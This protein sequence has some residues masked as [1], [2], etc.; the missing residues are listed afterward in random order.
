MSS[1]HSWLVAASNDNVRRT[2]S[3]SLEHGARPF[4]REVRPVERKDRPLH[5]HSY[6]SNSRQVLANRFQRGG[7]RRVVG[8]KPSSISMSGDSAD[9]VARR[10]TSQAARRR[11]T[12]ARLTRDEPGQRRTIVGRT[13]YFRRRT[14]PPTRLTHALQ[15]GAHGVTAES[16]RGLHRTAEHEGSLTPRVAAKRFWPDGYC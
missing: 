4:R 10:V 7:A 9:G 5:Q 15:R 14:S 3:R 16:I 6:L 8:I 2:E 11:R 12:D 13:E 1:P